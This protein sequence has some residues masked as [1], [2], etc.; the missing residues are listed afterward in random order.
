MAVHEV[1]DSSGL[2][3]P[4]GPTQY[5]RNIADVVSDYACG[6]PI[7]SVLSGSSRGLARS[8]GVAEAEVIAVAGGPPSLG[9]PHRLSQP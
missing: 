9:R 5:L 7:S 6:A 4:H 1:C 3:C 2:A 8:K